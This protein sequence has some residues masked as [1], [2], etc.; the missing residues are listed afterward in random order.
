MREAVNI[1]VLCNGNILYFEDIERCLDYTGCE[2]VMTAEAN[3]YN[4]A[5]FSNKVYPVWEIADQY[6]EVCRGVGVISLSLFVGVGGWA[7]ACVCVCVC[8]CVC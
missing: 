1:P 2:G 8:V 4:P 5:L 7:G 6:M 3:L